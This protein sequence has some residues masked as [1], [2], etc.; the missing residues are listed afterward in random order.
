MKRLKNPILWVIPSL[1]VV[2][3]CGSLI[4]A[5][6]A[7]SYNEA[8]SR[9]DS[10]GQLSKQTQQNLATAMHG[11]AFAYVKYMLYAEHARKTGH[12]EMAALFENTARTE[13]FE[14]FVEE[15]KLAGLV[16]SDEEN[17]R[18]AIAGESYEVTS[19]YPEFAAQ[20]SDAGDK[21]AAGQFSEIRK[22]ET[23]HRDAYKSAL[24]RLE[25]QSAQRR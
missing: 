14:H 6:R 5:G 4:Y 3:L 17:L 8:N 23:K 19:M 24:E 7:R 20:A 22:D 12:P 25:K 1:A 2:G 10:Q 11:E 9:Q 13:R 16:G 21:D 15:A 18:D